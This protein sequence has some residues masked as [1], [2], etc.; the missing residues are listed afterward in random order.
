M[1]GSERETGQEEVDELKA[2]KSKSAPQ[3]STS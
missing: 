3:K 1:S 2:T